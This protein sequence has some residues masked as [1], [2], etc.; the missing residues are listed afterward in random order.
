MQCDEGSEKPDLQTDHGVPAEDIVDETIEV[1][2]C[3]VLCLRV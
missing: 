3:V 2:R 1:H